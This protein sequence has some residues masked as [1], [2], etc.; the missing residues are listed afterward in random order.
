MTT[1]Y[2]GKCIV[3]TGAS[4]G[5][6]RAL[7]LALAP[8]RPRLVLAARDSESLEDVA[9]ECRALGAEAMVVPTDVAD[10]EAAAFLIETAVSGSATSVG[11]KIG[12]ASCRERV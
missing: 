7:A 6:G 2:A 10:P 9:G 4:S 8:Q 1:T 3:L 11:T 12:R 5:I